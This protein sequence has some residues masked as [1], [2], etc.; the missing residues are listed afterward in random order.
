[1]QIREKDDHSE[2]GFA[3]EFSNHSI[4]EIIVNFPFAVGSH[5]IANYE[6]YVESL[7]AWVSGERVFDREEKLTIVNKYNTS[8][9]EPK[10]D[11]DKKRGYEL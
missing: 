5:K 6:F 4:D 3:T 7:G 1:M 9:L 8:F 2:I 11:A 10:T